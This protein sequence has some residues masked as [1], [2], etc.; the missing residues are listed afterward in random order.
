MY[1]SVRSVLTKYRRLRGLQIE[2]YFLEARSSR[3]GCQKI[4]FLALILFLSCRRPSSYHVLTRPVLYMCVEM[5]LFNVF[6]SCL[7][8]NPVRL[9]LYLI[10]PSPPP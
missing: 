10:K 9:G 5:E 6:S 2:I 3:S 7:Y 4:W 1:L 8:T